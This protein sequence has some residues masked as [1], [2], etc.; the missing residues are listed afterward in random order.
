MRFSIGNYNFTL[1]L[2]NW[3]Y[4]CVNK[5]EWSI[6]LLDIN[7]YNTGIEIEILNFD[8]SFWVSKYG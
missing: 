4:L 5:K 2:T 1:T 7:I 3:W 8:I 6:T